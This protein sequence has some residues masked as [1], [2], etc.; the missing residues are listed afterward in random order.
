MKKCVERDAVQHD[1]C[2]TLAELRDRLEGGA[3]RRRKY[4]YPYTGF[5]WRL[6]SPT[7]RK[8]QGKVPTGREWY[9]TY[10]WSAVIPQTVKYK[11][12]NAEVARKGTQK[13]SDIV[14]RRLGTMFTK[15]F[16]SLQE[17]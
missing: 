11:L 14:V 13:D 5:S 7:A 17:P 2:E 8:L 6:A 15:H 10:D 9:L 16:H 3:A 1:F 12:Q 4:F